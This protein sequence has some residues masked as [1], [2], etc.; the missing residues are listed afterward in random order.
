LLRQSARSLLRQPG[1]LI[2]LI[3]SVAL[4]VGSNAA[5]FAFASGLISVRSPLADAGARLTTV[6]AQS[7]RSQGLLNGH[8]VAWLRDQGV[9][10]AVAAI[11]ETVG[12]LR[13]DRRSMTGAVATT[14]SEGAS[15]LSLETADGVALGPAAQQT[16][17][18]PERITIDDEAYDGP[19]STPGW[20]EGLFA[21]RPIAAW[22]VA[23][24]GS[25][26]ADDPDART[27]TVV[28]R[29]P[30]GVSRAEAQRQLD[31]RTPAVRLLLDEYTGLTPEASAAMRRLRVLLTVVAGAMLAITCL[32]VA[33]LLL[34]R[35][36]RRAH[37]IS[38]RIAL[39]VTRR[40]LAV[41]LL[42]D[43]V[44]IV[45]PGLAAGLLLGMWTANALP[46]LL[47]A[48]DAEQL[49]FAPDLG[50]TAA[51]VLA[52]A[53]LVVGCGMVP[54]V[55]NRH[56][57]PADVL[58][59]R[60]AHGRGPL[61]RLQ[62]SLV[63][64]QM[65]GCCAFVVAAAF[66]TDSFQSAL[67]TQAGRGAGT[68]VLA[69]VEASTGFARDDLGLQ[70]F[71]D[72]A[73]AVS[74]VPGVFS[75]AWISRAPGTH[76]SWRPFAIERPHATAREVQAP[77]LPFARETIDEVALP[78]L[79]GRM[80]GGGDRPGGCPVVVLNQHAASAWFGDAAVGRWLRSHAGERFEIIGVVATP[81]RRAPIVYFYPAQGGSAGAGVMRFALPSGEFHRGTLDANAV[82][83][84]YFQVM[85]GVLDDTADNE[86]DRGETPCRTAVVNQEAA[87][88]YFDGE[89]VGGA[90]IDAS[91]QRT[92][93]VGVV[94]EV[95]IGA[96]QRDTPPTIY[97]RHTD[98]YSPHATLVLAAASATPEM[99]AEVRRQ[100][101]A[102]SG[103]SVRRL[104][105]LDDHLARTALAAERIAALLVR[106]AT[107]VALVLGILGL[108]RAV[109]DDLW[110]RQQ[111][112]ATR[113]ALGS[114]AWRLVPV[115]LRQG[116]RW[117]SAGGLLGLLCAWV[118][119][120]WLRG[121]TGFDAPYAAWAWLAGPAVLAAGVLLASALPALRAI[122]V[123][124]LMAMKS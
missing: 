45:V 71:R 97:F 66:L 87:D 48:Q 13:T 18:A 84:N 103:G 16:F 38:I 106:A 8:E 34:S 3:L 36:A 82:S 54:L 122:R 1:L 12:T 107:A 105:T 109:A 111:E 10:D 65:A 23:D 75:T 47:F 72:L 52:C 81:A 56:D 78:P 7:G 26:G 55:E 120:I 22:I 44:L 20:L 91:G 58:R 51:A 115:L 74:Q 17:G 15:L 94:Q 79:A 85:G 28:A 19:V 96:W 62:K 117:A 113:S 11:R 24:A 2:G 90:V 25:L 61:D 49:T 121:L 123:D 37:E 53:A 83:G 60:A 9:F 35:A 102:V 93:I 43:A 41:G 108:N 32:N 4:G 67:R 31:A 5:I 27:L 14:S 6:I 114:P 99:L 69:E 63:V 70:Y 77:L 73:A 29:L 68:R 88:L 46:A 124:P 101:T 42:V 76:P 30:Q 119:G 92:T 33:V 95:P 110:R 57:R 80:F 89:A 40:T 98:E 112:F 118:V 21:G 104:Q 50:I 59:S 116:A 86:V 100:M 39:G 64:A